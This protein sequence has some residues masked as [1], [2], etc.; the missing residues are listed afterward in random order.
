[1]STFA[2]LLT[3]VGITACYSAAISSTNCSWREDF[4]NAPRPLN[5]CTQPTEFTSEVYLCNEAKELVKYSFGSSTDCSGSADSASIVT[6]RDYHCGEVCAYA[7]W[8]QCANYTGSSSFAGAIG[9]YGIC[10]EG[11]PGVVDSQIYTCE[12]GILRYQWWGVSSFT[13]N[14]GTDC[15]PLDGG[16]NSVLGES[17]CDTG[18][19][20]ISCDGSSLPFIT[21]VDSVTDDDVQTTMAPSK[22]P[23]AMTTNSSLMPTV[24]NTYAST[25][26][27]GN[28]NETDIGVTDESYG[29]KKQ[30]VNRFVV[31]IV[32]V[33]A[34][35]MC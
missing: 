13:G 10:F 1:M 7:T 16:S 23:I 20:I 14:K 21:Q 35:F 29:R 12:N 9:P 24:A 22:D 15:E 27:D 19:G 26:E 2:V 6:S 4:G 30:S 11:Y 32:F 31:F 28:Y 3:I 17:G 8:K 33:F 34:S 18:F 5:V 25:E